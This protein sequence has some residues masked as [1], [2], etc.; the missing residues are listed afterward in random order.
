M[1]VDRIAIASSNMRHV[2]PEN[3][4]QPVPFPCREL[5]Q[6]AYHALHRFR[7]FRY[8]ALV[9]ASGVRSAQYRHDSNARTKQMLKEE[10]GVIL[11]AMI[12]FMVVLFVGYLYALKKRAF[13]WKS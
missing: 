5:S 13:D 1:G 6:C 8:S 10:G 7:V 2:N 4:E 11:G 9:Q 12:S 3:P